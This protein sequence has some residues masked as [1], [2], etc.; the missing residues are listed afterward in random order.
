M[1]IDKK[2]E[3]TRILMIAILA[4]TCTV[5]EKP[6]MSLPEYSSLSGPEKAD[7]F[8]QLTTEEQFSFLGTLVAGRL[9]IVGPVYTLY[10]APDGCFFLLKSFHQ[11]PP[12]STDRSD[13]V[14]GHGEWAAVRREFRL[15]RVGGE[16]FAGLRK[17][18]ILVVDIEAV[19]GLRPES[20][21]FRLLDQNSGPR[22]G[23]EFG[24]TSPSQ[25]L[26]VSDRPPPTCSDLP[27]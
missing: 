23:I 13:S 22:M 19:E 8:N 2:T 4:L 7:Y 16:Y 6:R 3:I 25:W 10:F 27:D 14:V 11:P 21:L 12:G 1:H 18:S 17:D 20:V 26:D 9:F 5:C 24:W 15:N